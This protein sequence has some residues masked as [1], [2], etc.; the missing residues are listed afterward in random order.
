MHALEDAVVG[1]TFCFIVWVIF[2]SIRRYLTVKAQATLQE[3]VF[4][5][6]DSAPALLE[7]AASEA[8]NRFLE[9]LT[10]E[11][12]EPVSPFSRILYGIQAGIV[13]TFFG[14]GMLWLHHVKVD[15]SPGFLVLGTGAVGLGIGFIIAAAVSFWISRMLGLVGRDRRG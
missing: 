5:R 8:G 9:S 2:G 3:R 11:R 15:D 7:L 14:F 10:M 12:A 6:I 1:A 4:A 13:L